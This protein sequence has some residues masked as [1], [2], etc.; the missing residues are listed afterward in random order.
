MKRILLKFAF[1]MLVFAVVFIACR[2]SIFEM[3]NDSMNVEE[4]QAWYKAH[5]P[6]LLVLKSGNTQRQPKVVKPDWNSAFK[7]NNDKVEV[8]E[9]SLTSNGGFGFATEESHCAWETNKNIGYMTSLPRLVVMKDKKTGEIISFIMTIIGDKPY[10]EKNKFKLWQNSYL[11]KDRDFS[12]VVLFHNLEGTFVNGWKYTEGK[13]THTIKMDSGFDLSVKLKSATIICSDEVI[14]GWFTD[15][16]TNEWTVTVGNV[17]EYH[18]ETEC[19]DPYIDDIG[20]YQQCETTTN[21]SDNPEGSGGS[22][23][24]I[25]PINPPQNPIPSFSSLSTHFATVATKTAPQVYQFIGGNVWSNYQN[26][27]NAFSNACALRI[28][29]MLNMISGHHVPFVEGKTLSGDVNRD[30]VKEWYFYRVVDMVSYLNNVYGNSAITN[31]NN[32]QGTTGII[33]QDD[34]GWGDAT[35]HLDVWNGSNAMDHY[36]DTCEYVHIWRN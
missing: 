19:G 35:G 1:F 12:G 10:L 15:C 3:A 5:L 11:K 23:G 33:W 28:S 6:D 18:S 22:G 20:H 14:Y 31:T 29:Y 2:E 13:V 36:Y 34:C 27:P 7:S 24:Y 32:L 30:G 16:I 21:P 26:N 9:T 4:A 8:V 25:P 17:T